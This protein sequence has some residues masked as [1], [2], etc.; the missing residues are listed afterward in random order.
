VELRFGKD[1]LRAKYRSGDV[2]AAD[3]TVAELLLD[4]MAKSQLESSKPL[5]YRT[6]MNHVQADG[7]LWQMRAPTQERRGAVG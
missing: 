4:Y 5:R 3:G 2:P 1:K 7:A 6:L